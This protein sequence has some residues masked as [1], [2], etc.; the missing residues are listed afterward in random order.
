MVIIN[1]GGEIAAV[2]LN[3]LDVPVRMVSEYHSGQKN[4]NKNKAL[5][6][7]RPKLGDRVIVECLALR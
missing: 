4:K 5:L 3:G 6:F 7:C 2:L 1:S